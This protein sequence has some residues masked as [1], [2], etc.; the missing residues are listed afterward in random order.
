MLKIEDKDT[1]FQPQKRFLVDFGWDEANIG[2]HVYA[3]A[4]PA[5]RD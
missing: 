1:A 3:L 4:F 2:R 5:W